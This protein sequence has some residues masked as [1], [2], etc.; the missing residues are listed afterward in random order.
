M[1]RTIDSLVQFEE[2][3]IGFDHFFHCVF[4]YPHAY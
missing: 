3:S 1:Q 4:E 2:Y